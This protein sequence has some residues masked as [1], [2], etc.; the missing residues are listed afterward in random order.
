MKLLLWCIFLISLW[1]V[2]G[3]SYWL[4]RIAPW[5]WLSM[6][7][8]NMP[9]RLQYYSIPIIIALLLT[10]NKKGETK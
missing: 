9:D 7:C 10:K 8:Q 6:I 2:F 3:E 5:H 1:G 4:A